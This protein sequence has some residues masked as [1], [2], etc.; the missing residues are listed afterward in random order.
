MDL[1]AAIEK[2]VSCFLVYPFKGLYFL[3]FSIKK[4]ITG[5]EVENLKTQNWKLKPGE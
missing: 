2:G 3:L 4:V 1:K 5:W